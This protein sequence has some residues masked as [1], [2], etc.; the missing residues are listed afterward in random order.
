MREL[1]SAET[2]ADRVREL[3]A[4]IT[5]D[6]AGSNDLVLIGMLRGSVCFLPDLMRAIGLPMRIGFLGLHRY[7]GTVG[8]D[9]RLSA[10]ETDNIAGADVIVVEDIVEK[11]TTLHAALDLLRERLPGSLAVVALLQKPG[12][13]EFPLPELR[14][15]G[16]EAGPEWVVGYGLD[17]DQRYRNLPYIA[18]LEREDLANRP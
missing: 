17:L 12:L 8:G 13:A 4:E 11:G 2:I 3:G 1:I 16:F 9:L 7:D 18:A 6:Y 15:V 14:Y 10:D 5:R